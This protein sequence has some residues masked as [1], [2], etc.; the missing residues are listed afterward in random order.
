MV[1][2]GAGIAAAQKAQESEHPITP[3]AAIQALI[4]EAAQV[5]IR[6][7]MTQSE[8]FIAFEK[9]RPLAEDRP[10]EFTRQA[11]FYHN[12]HLGADGEN[13]GKRLAAMQLIGNFRT[14]D[15]ALVQA[16][17]PYLE[18][19]HS[20]LAV[21]VNRLLRHV[22]RSSRHEIPDYSAHQSLV[23]GAKE[24]PP[25]RL[26]KYMYDRSPGVAV[27]A[28][29]DVYGSRQEP[30][31]EVLWAEHVVSDNLWKQQKRFLGEKE[32]LPE[33]LAEVAKMAAHEE[34]WAR[35]YAAEI[36]AQHPEFGTPEMIEAFKNDDHELVREAMLPE[37]RPQPRVAP[38]DDG[39][40]PGPENDTAPREDDQ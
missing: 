30:F 22:E 23:Q 8:I 14:P 36:V 24:Q 17:V 12:Q 2:S 34:W 40:E 20:E 11:L 26:I 25:L 7:G 6:R 3:D 35:L 5:Y 27:L 37:E 15:T 10:V 29:L 19:D 33:A 21:E 9:L 18:T 13:M 39:D 16:V 28:L 38:A 4:D 31:R 32:T 1:L